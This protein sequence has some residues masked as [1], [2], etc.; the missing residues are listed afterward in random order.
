MGEETEAQ[1]NY[2]AGYA[3]LEQGDFRRADELADACLA[4]SSP[5]SYWYAGALGLKCWIA[6][7]TN[8]FADLELTATSLLASDTGLDKPWFEG[9]VLLNLGLAKKRSG[10]TSLAQKLFLQASERYAAQHLRPEQPNEW[11][12]V[13]D[14]FKT[15]CRWA[16][17]GESAFWE[18]FLDQFERSDQDEHGK[19]LW[20]LISASQLMLRHAKGQ[21]VRQDAVELLKRG[22]S[23][24]FLAVVLTE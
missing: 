19:L 6:N 24:T 11:R 23:R 1:E 16:A 7:F 9:L 8:N 22:V 12:K 21:E 2:F 5:N 4:V 13:L 20:Q 17:T 14:Y 3:A 15:L 18:Q 10:D